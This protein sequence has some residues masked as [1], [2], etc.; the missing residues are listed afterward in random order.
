MP[1]R[2][3]HIVGG[4]HPKLRLSYYTDMIRGLKERHPAGAHQ[5]AHRGRDRAPGPDREDDRAEVLLALQ[6]GRAHQHAGRRRG[7]VQHGGA[8]HHRRAEAHRRGMD[9]GAP[10]GAQL[11]IRT[12]CTMLYGHV[13][14]APTGSST[15]AM[16]RALQDET[17]G[18]LDLHPA[19]LSPGPQRAGRGA[20]PGGHGD[21]R[22]T[23]TSRTSRSAVFPGQHPARQDPLAHGH[24]VPLPDRA[25]ASAATTW[26]ARWSTSGSTTRP[27]RRPTCTC[28]SR[29]GPADSR[30]AGSAR[31]SAT[32]ST[33]RCA[34]V[35][36][37][38]ARARRS[39]RR[40]PGGA[41][42]MR[43]SG[44]IPW[45]NCYPVYGAI[46][47]GLVPVPRAGD[48]GPPSSSTTCWRRASST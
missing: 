40:P 30:G 8:R 14:T 48:A 16:L 42:R 4:L 41:R 43:S 28:L 26:K 39:P 36:R 17:G 13:E 29:P 18:F 37:S 35:R 2:E 3:F 22:A 47:R 6:G 27:A 19:G 10:D 21:D 24:A 38:A 12:N 7:G 31:W 23:R 45:I 46:D 1:T 34:T 20:G 15:S 33:A 5:G 9:P 44:R 32:A 11:G 25:R